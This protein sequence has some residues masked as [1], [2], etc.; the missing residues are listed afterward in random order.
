M[1]AMITYRSDL[2]GVDWHALRQDLI[3]DRF[4]NGRTTAQLEASFSNSQHVAV[5]FDTTRCIG[6]ARALSDGIG[7]A[8]I[9][10]A[11]T[12][13]EYRRRGI[14]SELATRLTSALQGQHV[15]L[16]TDDA[17]DFWR[18]QGFE[19][20]PHGLSLIVGTYLHS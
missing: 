18:A 15:Y 14:A 12:K 4:H 13:R 1:E 16:Q 8:Y 20:Q 9:L 17:L 6:T 10:D 3:E 7:N 19:P 11:W 2:D 5:A